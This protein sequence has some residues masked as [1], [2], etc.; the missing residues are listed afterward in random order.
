MGVAEKLAQ[1]CL[2][3]LTRRHHTGFWHGTTEE[4]H[5]IVSILQV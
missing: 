1:K 4:G 3:K 2:A 5:R